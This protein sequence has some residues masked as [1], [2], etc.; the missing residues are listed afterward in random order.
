MSLIANEHIGNV[1]IA[2]VLTVVIGLLAVTLLYVSISSVS[3]VVPRY[4]AT[5]AE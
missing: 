4:A 1:L 2:V 3:N 5:T